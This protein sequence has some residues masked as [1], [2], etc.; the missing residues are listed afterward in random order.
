MNINIKKLVDSGYWN[1]EVSDI[2]K[3]PENANMINCPNCK[4]SDTRRIQNALT[5][6][7]NPIFTQCAEWLGYCHECG[8]LYEYYT[9]KIMYV[10]KK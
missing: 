9:D 5:F 1:E 7:N 4:G 8:T 6:I 10:P 2:G 3:I